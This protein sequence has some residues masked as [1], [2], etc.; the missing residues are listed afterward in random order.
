MKYQGIKIIIITSKLA[1]VMH[2]NLKA[3][4]ATLFTLGFNYEAQNAP[5]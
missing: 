4:V 3:A 5:E 2:F 1:I